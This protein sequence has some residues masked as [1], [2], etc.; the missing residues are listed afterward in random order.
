MRN[1]SPK[2]STRV[3]GSPREKRD[4]ILVAQSHAI[5]QR[6]RTWHLRERYLA[7]NEESIPGTSRSRVRPGIRLI[8][9]DKQSILKR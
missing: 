7:S 9:E 8:S 4:A 5:G 6:K 2:H 1:N 3:L